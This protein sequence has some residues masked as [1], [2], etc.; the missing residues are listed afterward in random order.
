MSRLTAAS[1]LLVLMAGCSSRNSHRAPGTTE[2]NAAPPVVGS[3]D[4]AFDGS[5]SQPGETKTGVGGSG[6]GKGTG[7]DSASEAAARRSE[8]G[9]AVPE[10]GTILLVGTGLAAAALS[11]KRRKA[12]SETPQA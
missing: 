10:P 1:L 12:T 9:A 5:P 2:R 4:A 11:R 8:R 3:D 6:G 7:G